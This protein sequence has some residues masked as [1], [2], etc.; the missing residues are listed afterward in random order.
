MSR[1]VLRAILAAVLAWL[2]GGAAIAQAAVASPCNAVVAYAYDGHP[3]LA[4]RA[5]PASE[6]GPPA[7]R[8]HDAD[9]AADRWSR[10]ALARP[11]VTAIPATCDYDGTPGFVHPAYGGPHAVEPAGSAAPGSVVARGSGVAA[12]GVPPRFITTGAGTTIDRLAISTSISARRQGR[13]VLGARQYGG[14]S[15]FNSADDAQRVNGKNFIVQDI[16]SHSGGL[17]KMADTIKGLGSKTT[18]SGTY[19]YDL[20]YIAP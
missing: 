15:Y 2:L 9:D 5:A 18:R 3:T 16:D 20:N 17:W 7:T 10:G 14:G 1:F 13:H 6:R 11:D 8:E 12:N 19:D 4:N